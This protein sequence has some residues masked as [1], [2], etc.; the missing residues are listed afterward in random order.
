MKPVTHK[1]RFKLST[2]NSIAKIV[3]LV[4]HKAEFKLKEKVK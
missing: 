1:A 4:T 3:K 2:Q